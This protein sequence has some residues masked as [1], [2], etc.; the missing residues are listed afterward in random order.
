MT[1][2]LTRRKFLMGAG[3][4]LA[5]PA[6]VRVSSLMPVRAHEWLNTDPIRFLVRGETGEWM[7]F[8][9]TDYH[10]D[11][12]RVALQ[13]PQDDREYRAE[14]VESGEAITFQSVNG[15]NQRVHW[16]PQ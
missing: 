7:G 16:I 12:Q 14:H 15:F 9:F 3:V 6:I 1:L 10:Y 8:K 5:A 4:L 2:D 13:V 11:G